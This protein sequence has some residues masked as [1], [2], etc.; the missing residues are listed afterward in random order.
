MLVPQ[1]EENQNLVNLPLPPQYILAKNRR[2]DRLRSHYLRDIL[3][4]CTEYSESNS[5]CSIH[6]GRTHSSAFKIGRAVLTAEQCPRIHQEVTH[7]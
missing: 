7:G 6:N 1:S 4:A 5:V 3:F 2:S